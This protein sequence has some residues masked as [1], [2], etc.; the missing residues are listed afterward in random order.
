MKINNFMKELLTPI[1]AADYLTISPSTFAR[2]RRNCEGF[3][4]PIRVGV[5]RLAWR[6]AD[7]ADWLETR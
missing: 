3:P 2:V 6:T 1:E 5:R 7:L 4:P